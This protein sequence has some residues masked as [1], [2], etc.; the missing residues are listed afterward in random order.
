[1]ITNYDRHLFEKGTHYEIYKKFGAHIIEKDGRF[2]VNFSLWAPNAKS[3]GVVGDFNGWNPDAHKMQEMDDSGIYE[4]FIADLGECTIYKYVIETRDG[5]LLYKSDPYANLSEFRPNTASIVVDI[6]NYHWSDNEWMKRPVKEESP[7][8]IYE[9]HLASFMR[10][11]NWERAGF[12]SYKE[13]AHLLVKYVKK[14]GYTHVEL[15]GIA[16]HPFDGSWGY[17]VTG[18]YAPTSRHGGPKDFKYFVD[19][20]HQNNIGVILDW[21]PAHFPKDEH[22]LVMFDGTCLYEYSDPKMNEHSEWGTKIF[23]YGKKEV[24]NFLIANALFW[25]E[26]FH[27]DGLRVDAVASMLYLDY[28][29]SYGNWIPNIYGG[30][31][32]LDAVEF[33]RHLN[34]IIKKRVPKAIVIAEESTAWPKVTGEIRDGALGFTHKWNMG[35]M[36]DFLEYVKQDPL[37]RKHHHHKLTFGMTYAFSENFILVIS[38][39]EVVHL[40]KSMLEKMPGEYFSKFSN[41]K[42][43]YGFMFGHPGKKLLFM[44]QDF[45]QKREW[46]EERQL[47]WFLLEERPHQDLQNYVRKLLH[48]YTNYPALYEQDRSWSGFEWINCDDVD[49]SIFSFLRL[50]KSGKKDLLFICNFTPVERNTYRVGVPCAGSYRVILDST[51]PGSDMEYKSSMICFAVEGECDQRPYYIEF[52][53]APLSTIIMEFDQIKSN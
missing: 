43:A 28:N 33:F 18:Y 36:N 9:V 23:D 11:E 6:E 31:E 15:I 42:T 53:L 2:G 12:Y 10:S 45:G 14:M 16:E 52:T 5:S 19:Y 39:D 37:F 30:N 41:L 50:S 40:K 46:S 34:Q 48:I 21:V 17:Q 20:M 35:W 26:E 24:S 38:H 49:R 29:K 47:D 51:K 7:M 44:G 8:A 3:V 27:I 4:L 22:G 25:L 1:M 13:L 32:N